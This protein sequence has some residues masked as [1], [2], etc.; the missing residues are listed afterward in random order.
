MLLRGLPGALCL[1]GLIGLLP[2]GI[3]RLLFGRLRGALRAFGLGLLHCCLSA[4]QSVRRCGRRCRGHCRWRCRGL[5]RR[6]GSLLRPLRRLPLPQQQSGLTRLA[7]ALRLHRVG[8]GGACRGLV[9]LHPAQFRLGGA[10]TFTP[11]DGLQFGIDGRECG[12]LVLLRRVQTIVDQKP[13]QT[14]L[15]LLLRL[16][17]D[18]GTLGLQFGL[19]CR[20]LLRRGRKRGHRAQRAGSQ[21][22]V[23]GA[24]NVAQVHTKV[25]SP[26]RRP[27]RRYSALCISLR[28]DTVRVNS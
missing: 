2:R 21:D 16:R 5:R 6:R 10:Q 26:W 22:A 24:A 28:R 12:A 23:Q 7:V 1:P 11:G 27:S 20:I 19:P 18:G 14:R 8:P 4:L 15:A 13:L 9:G 17:L 3:R 25:A